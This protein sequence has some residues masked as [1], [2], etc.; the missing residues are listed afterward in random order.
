MSL[1]L[2]RGA[3]I[4]FVAVTPIL[5]IAAPCTTQQLGHPALVCPL[6]VVSQQDCRA[7]PS[8]SCS[9]RGLAVFHDPHYERPSHAY[10]SSIGLTLVMSLKLDTFC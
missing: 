1:N 3:H 4:H 2:G 6:H 10:F 9:Q 5:P 8:A 7:G